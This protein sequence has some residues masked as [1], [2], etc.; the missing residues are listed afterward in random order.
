M[1]QVLELEDEWQRHDWSRQKRTRGDWALSSSAEA[2][3]VLMGTRESA[4]SADWSKAGGS[5]VPVEMES[6]GR[7]TIRR[8]LM[9]REC[10]EQGGHEGSCV[11]SPQEPSVDERRK[12]LDHCAPH[13]GKARKR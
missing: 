2:Q 10:R 5:R 13:R 7:P 12:E 4:L 9:P 1:E 6:V 3:D 8:Y 11:I